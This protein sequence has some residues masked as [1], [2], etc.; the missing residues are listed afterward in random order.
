MAPAKRRRHRMF[1][2]LSEWDADI[3]EDGIPGGVAVASLSRTSLPARW[4]AAVGPP[5][6]GAVRCAGCVTVCQMFDTCDSAVGHID[7]RTA[8]VP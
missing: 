8:R 3:G 1:E 7:V 4:C 5:T 6:L 2:A